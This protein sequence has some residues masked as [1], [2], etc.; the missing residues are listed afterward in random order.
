VPRGHDQRIGPFDQLVKFTEAQDDGLEAS[1]RAAFADEPSL[2]QPVRMCARSNVSVR[3][4]QE[5]RRSHLSW[6]EM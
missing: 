4:A 6:K 1:G 5:E 3:L 2:L